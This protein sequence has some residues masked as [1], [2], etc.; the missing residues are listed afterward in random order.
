MV[1]LVPIAVL[2]GLG[3]AQDWLAASGGGI[4]VAGLTLRAL[5]RLRAERAVPVIRTQFACATAG[6]RAQ[7]MQQRAYGMAFSR[8][9][10]IA[11]PQHPQR[12]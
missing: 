6:V 2:A 3:F 4:A 12:P 1:G 11:R 8:F 5:I 7:R 9:L 10:E